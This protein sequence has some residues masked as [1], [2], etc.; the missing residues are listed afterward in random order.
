MTNTITSLDLPG[1]N[2]PD[3]V[4]RKTS[5]KYLEAFKRLAG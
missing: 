3:E 1:L 4:I 5:K 2:L